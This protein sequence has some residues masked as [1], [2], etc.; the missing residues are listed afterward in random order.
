M[1]R[2]QNIAAQEKWGE[3][4]RTGN[5]EVA[6]EVMDPN[7]VDHDPAPDQAPGPEGFKQFF[8]AMR[9]AF[10]DLESSVEYMSATDDDVAYAYTWTGTHRGEF[11]GVA[12]T[13]K[14]VTIRGCQIFRFE[15]GKMV[16]RWGSTDQLGILQQLGAV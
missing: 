6:Y 16:E 5:L 3:G 4:V 2:E 15:N 7:I 10:P 14:R 12:P 13:G 11:M 8:E 9:R 1:T